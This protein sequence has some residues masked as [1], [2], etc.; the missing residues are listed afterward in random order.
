[1]G[2][3]GSKPA[4]DGN[5][6]ARGPGGT[7]IRGRGPGQPSSGAIIPPWSR[8]PAAPGA[9]SVIDAGA[10]NS[11]ATPMSQ[12][13]TNLVAA[14]AP[15]RLPYGAV[16]MGAQLADAMLATFSGVTYLV[17]S[18]VWGQGPV[19]SID[20]V[21]FNAATPPAGVVI[22]NYTGT[23]LVP[24]SILASAY[25]QQTPPIAYA[26]VLPGIAYSVVLIPVLGFSAIPEIT[27]IIRGLK[28]F[29][30]RQK[31]VDFDAGEIIDRASNAALNPGLASWTVE[32]WVKPRSYA[33]PRSCFPWSKQGTTWNTTS[34]WGIGAAHDGVGV[35]FF[36]CDGTHNLVS[37]LNCDTGYRPTDFLGQ[38]THLAVV[39]DRTA[40]LARLYVNGQPQTA[41]IDISTV[42]GSVSNTNNLSFGSS[43]G[44]QFDGQAEELRI[45]NVARSAAQISDYYEKRALGTETGLVLCWHLLEGAGTVAT[46]SSASA[47]NGTL[48][49]T[50][51]WVAGR[52]L[53]PADQ[54]LQGVYSDNPALCTAD[55]I[56]NTRYGAGLAI[57]WVSVGATADTNDEI[58][59]GEKRRLIGLV[60]DQVAELKRWT[61]AF[62]AYAGCF[63]VPG[64]KL[65]LVPDR[66]TS[67]T[68]TFSESAASPAPANT[69]VCRVRGVAKTSRR[70]VPTVVAIR[71]TDTTQNPW[72]DAIA[73]AYAA[74]VTEGSALWRPRELALPG[75]QR[76]SQ[77]KREGIEQLNKLT[78]ND[79]SWEVDAADEAIAVQ[80]GDVTQTTAF[81]GLTAKPGR[82][83]GGGMK[84]PG[85]FNF[86][87]EEYDP[88]AYSDDVSAGPSNPDTGLPS[89]LNVAAP[90]ALV[91]AER[92]YLER[93]TAADSIARGI[94][95]QSRLEASWTKST[96]TFPVEYR[97][98][99][100]DLVG[101]TPAFTPIL[102]DTSTSAN[103]AYTSPA[104]QQGVQYTLRVW[105]RNS[106]GFESVAPLQ[107]QVTALGKGLIPSD[108]P[109]ITSAFE[110]G[111]RVLLAWDPSID[112]D[113]LRYEWRYTPNVTTGGSWE[114]STFID[115]VDALTAE[116]PGLVTGTHRFYVKARDSIG[117]PSVNAAFVDVTVTSDVNAFIQTF[118]YTTPTLS[119]MVSRRLPDDP[120]TDYISQYGAGTFASIFTS[121]LNTYTNPLVTYFGSGTSSL[122]TEAKDFGLALTGDIQATWSA[123]DISGTGVNTI[124]YSLDGSTWQSV[125]GISAK[126]TFRYVRLKRTTTGFQKIHGMPTVKLNVLSRF[127]ADYVTSLVSGGALVQLK[128]QYV[129]AQ[130]LQ[131]TPSNSS[132]SRNAV[133]DRL[134]VH[135]QTG[136]MHSFTVVPAA[137]DE[138]A[139]A[140]FSTA[141]RTILADD[142]LE[143]DV[144]ID[145][146]TPVADATG[147]Q[148][149][150]VINFTDA[151]N[152]FS[153]AAM[154]DGDGY[155]GN[156]PAQGFDALARGKW[157][158]RRIPIGGS[159]TKISNA[160]YLF[161][162]SD[163][164]GD[165]KI[166][167]RNIRITSAAGA[168]R[169]QLW[170]SGEPSSNAFVSTNITNEQMG[171]SNSFLVYCFTSNTAAQVAAT[172]R[173][174]FKGF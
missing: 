55:V 68:F 136:L 70:D 36:F 165:H 122:L 119:N 26:D 102:V 135:P 151:T 74:G 106:L 86:R 108:V 146:T 30:C 3:Q 130:D 60:V 103:L 15:I 76:Y 90:T 148:G 83:V 75:I 138:T 54:L 7:G 171:P 112:V 9:G 69:A 45:W 47:L 73:Y 34:G 63:V 133:W 87:V 113:V 20:G 140:Q 174:N 13:L 67:S 169:L 120:L 79:L 72:R 25:V 110:V 126:G 24:D 115:I 107:G 5:P 116:F 17:L 114:T 61:E 157:K 2:A 150:L 50:I 164:A 118:L 48:S 8:R 33:N 156:L 124:E 41:T 37:V 167:Y 129:A 111:G 88:A 62:R 137:G 46:D 81:V 153:D 155:N 27:A 35:E 85:R 38:W 57:D 127:E 78:L 43:V 142:Y 96:H 100:W 80:V 131:V 39:F 117:Q 89:P 109:R 104:V 65:K 42:T 92:A 99:L 66:P 40:G 105:A 134:L 158:S 84:A 95:Y 170:S 101:I 97:V 11:V 162:P 49:G 132:A 64:D 82:I 128:G 31:A 4:V 143:Y 22:A 139:V 77:A 23:Q 123:T 19:N 71:Y 93:A 91:M 52:P 21:F 44:W 59:G 152:S 10:V 12:T 16:L 125:T 141:G 161:Q 56:S 28:V 160:W 163:L 18:V 168:L 14:N 98:E 6:A 173:W 159:A 121:A 51:A 166:L 144:W 32:G 29:E 94:I 58:V 1:M 147:S 154:I 149:G 145:A 53:A 172:V